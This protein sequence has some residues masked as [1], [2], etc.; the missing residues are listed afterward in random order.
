MILR[1]R[2]CRPSRHRYQIAAIHVVE[3]TLTTLPT[4]RCI[5]CNFA[6]SRYWF[7]YPLE[8]S[9]RVAVASQICTRSISVGLICINSCRLMCPEPGELAIWHH[10]NAS[11]RDGEEHRL[12]TWPHQKMHR[13]IWSRPE[14]RVV[15]QQALI[16]L[17]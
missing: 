8:S 1:K 14:A 6:S 17:F 7:R 13:G 5:E 4:C 16:L 15:P 10:V 12:Q 2:R 11:P 3:N 9:H